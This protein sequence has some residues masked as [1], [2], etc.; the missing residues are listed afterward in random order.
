[1]KS[2]QLKIAGIVTIA[3][4]L[5]IICLFCFHQGTKSHLD[6]RQAE[7]YAYQLIDNKYDSVRNEILISERTAIKIANRL[8]SEKF[9]YWHTLLWKPFDIYLINGYWSVYGPVSKSKLDYGPMIIINQ[10]NG[11]TRL[12]P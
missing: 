1:M 10:Y 4:C 11:E 3:S 9:G 7:F 12:K 2:K 5:L 6:A 8:F